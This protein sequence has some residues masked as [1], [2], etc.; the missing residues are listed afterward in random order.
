[1]ARHM[2][3]KIAARDY[4]YVQAFMSNGPFRVE[5]FLVGTPFKEEAERR[6]RAYLAERLGG[7][8][9]TDGLHL[10]P[11]N[12][13]RKA[14]ELLDRGLADWLPYAPPKADEDTA[15]ADLLG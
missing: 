14:Q 9:K 3:P 12:Y 13:V 6:A 5:Y 8:V 4:T 15:L 11:R 10:Y 7:D 1:M 2:D